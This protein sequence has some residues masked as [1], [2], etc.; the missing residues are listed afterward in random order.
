LSLDYGNADI[1]DSSWRF[2]SVLKLNAKEQTGEITFDT[3]PRPGGVWN[4]YRAALNRTDI[5]NQISREAVVGIAH[6]WGVQSVPSQ[7]LLSA[8]QERLSIAGAGEATNR[9]LFAGYRRTFRTTEDI[10]SPRRGFIGTLEA[11]VGLPGVSSREFVRLHGHVNWLIPAGARNDILLRGEAGWVL[12]G[13]RE[14]IPSSFLFRTGGDQTVRGYS[15][16]SL[17]VPLGQAIVGGRYLALASAEYTRWITETLGAA[18]FVDAGDAFDTTR[19]FDL[20]AGYGLGVRWRS[21]VG[22]F[23]VDLAYGQ[24]VHNVRLHFSVGYAF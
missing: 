9:A 19:D 17:G 7:V 3:P 5:Q 23:R 11:G 1:F 18:V 21:P 16:Q 20:A 2:R 24:R 15:Y 4:T 22:P 8:H 12:A 13:S 10:V 6:N 14:G